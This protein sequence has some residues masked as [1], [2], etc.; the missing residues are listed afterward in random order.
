MPTQNARQPEELTEDEREALRRAH[1]RLRKTSQDLEA[2]L[3]TPKMRGRWDPAPVPAEAMEGAKSELVK[4]YA[5]LWVLQRDLLGW[6]LP[7][8]LEA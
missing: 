8:E 6:D 1:I 7:A 3:A 5:K 2:L 4:A